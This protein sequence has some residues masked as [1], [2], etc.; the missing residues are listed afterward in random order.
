MSSVSEMQAANS[1]L[2]RIALGSGIC[3]QRLALRIET[4]VEVENN[5]PKTLWA[6][7]LI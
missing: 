3:G 6:E 5:N 2:L 7:I 1:H 4:H